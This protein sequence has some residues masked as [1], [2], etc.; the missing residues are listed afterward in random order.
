MASPLRIEY[1]KI[2]AKLGK[3]NKDFVTFVADTGSGTGTIAFIKEF[4][5]RNFNVGIAEQ[6]M[7]SAA[8]G[9][10]TLGV[11]VFAN[12]YGVFAACRAG[13]QVRNS[14][15]YP[16]MNVKIVSSHVGL[17]AGAD[18]ASHQSVEDLAVMRA[19]P[20]MIVLVPA[21]R[22]ELEAMLRYLLKHPGPAYMR[23][24]RMA[25]EDIHRPDY[26]YRLGKVPVLT[27][28]RDVTIIATGVLVP[29]AIKAGVLLKEKGISAEVINCSTI[30]PLDKET[31]LNS[32]RKTRAAVTAEDHNILGGLGGAVG[33]LLAA[34]LPSPMEFVGMRDTFGESG[35][36]EEL[37][38]KYGMSETHIVAAAEK[39]IGKKK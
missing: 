8:A 19:I 10:S 12:T 26:V 3:E 11:T 13:D 38:V 24:T 2:L 25:M 15:G 37:L 17:D 29:K 5:E 39:V 21:D 14:I 31:I 30:K 32:L 22:I 33:E 16:K 18:G 34:E 1:G 20:N 7:F 28:G 23:T 6:N 27:E 35:D 36:M 9:F 4:P